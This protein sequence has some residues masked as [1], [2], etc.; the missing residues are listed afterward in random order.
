M[1]IEHMG[2]GWANCNPV[3][4]NPAILQMY[5][6]WD[7]FTLSLSF[8]SELTLVHPLEYTPILGEGGVKVERAVAGHMED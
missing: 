2:L 3:G 1:L 8:H 6:P 5:I 7:H 4:A